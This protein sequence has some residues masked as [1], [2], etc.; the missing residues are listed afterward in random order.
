MERTWYIKLFIIIIYGLNINAQEVNI[1]KNLNSLLLDFYSDLNTDDYG[2]SLKLIMSIDSS[3]IVNNEL[4]IESLAAYYNAKGFV[5]YNNNLNPEVYLIK[6]DSLN[7]LSLNP[8]RDIKVYTSFLLGEYYYDK[9]EDLKAKKAYSKIIAFDSIPEKFYGY[10]STALNKTF[11]IDRSLISEK[12]NDSLEAKNTAK[13]IINFNKLIKD[14]L[15]FEYGRSLEFLNHKKAAEGIFLNIK[16]IP[17]TEVRFN[18]YTK[19]RSLFWL[20]NFYYKNIGNYG[21]IDTLS[22]HKLFRVSE[23]LLSIVKNTDYLQLHSI[24]SVYSD[25]V[26]ASIITK[27]QKNIDLYESKILSLLNKPDYPNLTELD[28][29]RFYYSLHKLKMYFE[30][31]K[32]Y[33]KAKFYAYKTAQLQKYIYGEVSVE[34]EKELRSY[35]NIIQL[36]MFDYEEAYKISLVREQIIKKLYNEDSIEYLQ[37][38]YNQYGIRLNQMDHKKGLALLEKAIKIKKKIDCK[39]LKLCDDIWLAYL[40]CLN[41]NGLYNKPLELTKD[42]VYADNPA[43]LFRISSIRRFSYFG[44][45]NYI[46]INLEFEWLLDKLENYSEILLTDKTI[47]T[48]YL[49]FIKDYQ[50]HLRSTGRLDK[51]LSFS[52][53]NLNKFEDDF[54][55]ERNNFVLNYLNILLQLNK[56]SEALNFIDGN[57]VLKFDH[58]TTPRSKIADSNELQNRL[59]RIY[60]CLGDNIKAIQAY[61]QIK[62]TEDNEFTFDLVYIELSRL[63]NLTGNKE[64]S[65][66]YLSLF[67]ENFKNES[68]NDITILYLLV[69][70]YITI[71]QDKKAIEILIPLTEKIMDEIC[72]KSFFS[73]SDN[74]TD[75]LLHDETISNILSVNNNE[76]YNRN[77]LANA[78]WISNLYKKRLDYYAQINIDIQKLKVLNDP[79]ALKLQ[80]LENDFNKNPTE[81]LNEEIGQVKTKIIMSRL[82]NYEQLCAIDFNKILNSVNENELIIDIISYNNKKTRF[83]DFAVNFVSKNRSLSFGKIVFDDYYKLDEKQNINSYFFDLIY[84]EVLKAKNVN[85]NLIETFYII[86]S[87]KSNIIN[88]SALSFSLEEKLNKKVKVHVINSLLDIPKIKNEKQKKIDNLILIGDINYDKVSYLSSMVTKNQTRGIQFA[89]SIESSGIP[90]WGY[91]PGTKLEIEQIKQLGVN[92]KIN[93]SVLRGAEV[94][95]INLKKITIDQAENNVI[96][97]ATH[98]YFFPDDAA[99]ETDNLYATHNNPLLRSGLV[100]S[101]AN[102]FWNKN[103]LV[104]PNKDGVLTAEEISFMDLRGVDL[105]VLSACDTGLGVVSNLEG[106]NGL[107]RA[108]KLAGA[109]KLIMS[110]WKVPDR[111]TVEFFGY[112]YNF[113]LEEKLS[114]NESF[115]ETQ[116]I[117]KDKYSPY[118]W[119]GFVLLE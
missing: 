116:R 86:P 101:G 102:E 9:K 82:S 71:E 94:T 6:A 60:N 76:F 48:Y 111:E 53:E 36:K 80:N 62:K 64:E 66:K 97:V 39:N 43:L 113:L 49:E 40:S 52:N 99:I 24:Y 112:F 56:C 69:D 18:K 46:G 13:K 10:K 91:L 107:Q 79:V 75:K 54:I 72:F 22:A 100:L 109:N 42:L 117:M 14:T 59:G 96:H 12:N 98:A 70:L 89:N 93:V 41:Q 83:N 11:F 34:Y 50:E 1:N 32:Y 26:V 25:I 55:Y 81:L 57:E 7:N 106:V 63:Y 30:I 44:L 21:V 28:L 90:R 3:L 51:A 118:Y 67:E 110:L 114:I 20:N 17:D 74:K 105:I 45:G 61:K 68:L 103:S 88:F 77:L 16:S 87:G 23:E 15:N 92:N 84:N 2:K 29:G 4:N 78:Q 8:N 73:N 115:R 65:N 119:A 104:D 58:I 85:G 33:E 27:D 108:L 19:F 35:Q 37:L 95:E 38:L 31:G 5:Y 47:T